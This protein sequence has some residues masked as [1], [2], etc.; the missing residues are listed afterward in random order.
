M[1]G[2][3]RQSFGEKAVE[4]SKKADKYL[5]VAGTGIYVLI[6]ST[7]GAAIVIGS[8]LTLLPAKAVGGWLKKRR[9]R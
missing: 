3:E 9:T 8:V 7:I 2:I 4:L 6:N 5:I 1:T